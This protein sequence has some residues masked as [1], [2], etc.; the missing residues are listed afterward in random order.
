M[1]LPEVKNFKQNGTRPEDQ[2]TEERAIMNMYAQDF[3]DLKVLNLLTNNQ[4]LYQY[5]LNQYKETSHSRIQSEK[6][7]QEQRLAKYDL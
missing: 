2:E 3:D 6:V 7:L 4:E 5:K 1:Y